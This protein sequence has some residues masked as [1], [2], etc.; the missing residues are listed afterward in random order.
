MKLLY[1]RGLRPN[2]QGTTSQ[3]AL[4]GCGP[5]PAPLGGNKPKLLLGRK[6]E[7]APPSVS[8]HR[9]S[10]NPVI[11]GRTFPF[12]V[13]HEFPQ[14][15]VLWLFLPH[16][17]PWVSQQHRP[18]PGGG[19]AQDSISVGCHLVWVPALCVCSGFTWPCEGG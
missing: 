2:P 4:L 14:A 3:P 7:V 10:H 12:C 9:P 18:K 6:A 17:A 5:C 11:Q 19:W 13:E 16:I 1:F 15:L 8:F